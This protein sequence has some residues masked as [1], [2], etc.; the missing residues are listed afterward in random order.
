M[1]LTALFNLPPICVMN[2][3]TCDLRVELTAVTMAMAKTMTSAYS[4]APAP[5]S[6]AMNWVKTL[7]M[8][9]LLS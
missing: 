5:A 8:I 4:T 9:E 2:A 3:V 6:S 1:V 7:V